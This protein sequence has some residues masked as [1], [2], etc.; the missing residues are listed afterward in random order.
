MQSNGVLQI[1]PLSGPRRITAPDQIGHN[2]THNLRRKKY[3]AMAEALV[4]LKFDVLADARNRLSVVEGHLAIAG[5]VNDE[6]GGLNR[7]QQ[8]DRREG[9]DWPVPDAFQMVLVGALRGGCQAQLSAKVTRD[10]AETIR[11]GDENKSCDGVRARQWRAALSNQ[12]RHEATKRMRN[13]SFDRSIGLAHAEHGARAFG[14]VCAPPG[15]SPMR[16][17][18]E[19]HHTKS[20]PAQRFDEGR[21]KG[22]L[23]RPAVHEHHGAAGLS[24]RLEHVRLHHAGRRCDLPPV[25]IAQMVACTLRQ[26]MMIA[27]AMLGLFRRAEDAKREVPC[28]GGR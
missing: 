5:P 13:R 28:F 10:V 2:R 1:V 27:R 11:A 4:C 19:Q 14:E 8:L 21:H 16:W 12:K 6:R 17:E 9:V 26:V 23:A 24:V 25:C 20:R 18:V 3:R 7:L 15:T 22:R